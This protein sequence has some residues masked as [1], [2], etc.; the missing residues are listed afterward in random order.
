MTTENLEDDELP[1]PPD[2]PAL[3]RQYVV[4]SVAATHAAVAAQPLAL[5]DE[6]REQALHVLSFAL[7][8]AEAW[9]ATR[10]LLLLLAPKM[11]Q[12]GYRDDWIPYLERGVALSQAQDDRRAEGELCLYLGEL[13]RLRSKFELAR[14][15]LNTSIATFTALGENQGQAR[16]LNQ[17]AYVAWQQ[18]HYDEAES[19]A[20]C[21][22]TLLDEDDIERAT[23]FSRLGLVAIDQ[24]QW[25]EAEHYHRDALRIRQKY[26]DQRKIA[27]SLQNLGYALRGQG[28]YQGAIDYYKQAI[29]ILKDIQDIANCANVQI[30]LGIVYWLAEQPAKALEVYALAEYILGKIHDMY[31]L[32][33]V[34]NNK[35]LCYLALHDWGQAEHAFLSSISLFQQISDINLRLNVLDGLG[36]AYL[37]QNKYD[38]AGTIFQSALDELPQ[39]AGTAMYDYLAGILPTHLVQARQ[40]GEEHSR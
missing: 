25:E 33:A 10:D 12:A 16:A 14:Q 30:N 6:P 2:Y 38:K 4:R 9:P 29:A 20:Q 5:A 35:G 7:K 21:A 15:W 17:L 27:W 36:L 28:K 22:L 40:K 39:I 11:E 18:H 34:L 19:L 24:Q 32:A 3:F 37:G 31:N 8:L 13:L 1:P 23:C 26:D